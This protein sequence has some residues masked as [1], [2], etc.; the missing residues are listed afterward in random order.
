MGTGAV[1]TFPGRYGTHDDQQLMYILFD[2]TGSVLALMEEFQKLGGS[3]T[4]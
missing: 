4:L 3:G 1:S 2:E